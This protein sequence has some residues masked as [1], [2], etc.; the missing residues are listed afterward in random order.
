MISYDVVRFGAP[1]ERFE[2]PTPTP[3]GTEVL[4]K[5]IAAGV[6]HS[7]I[8]IRSGE[9][10]LGGGK[11]LQMG[12]RG[13]NLPL[14]MGHETV[15]EVIA[16]GPGATGVKAGD[17]RLVFPW[18]GCGTCAVCTRGDENLCMKAR[19]LGVYTPG[20]YSDHIVVPHPRY[21]VDIGDLPPEQ[22][23]P[24][25]CSG[26][27]TYSALRKIPAAVLER[28]PVVILG[29]GGL[30]L[31][32]VQILQAMGGH[33]SIV[34]DIDPKKREAAKEAGAL[35]VIDGAAPDAAKQLR[36]AAGG[37]IWAAIDYV[38]APATAELAIA[39]LVKGGQ[40]VVV[41]LFGGE[42]SVSLPLLPLRAMTI[43]GSYTG[44][45]AELRDLIALV[46]RTKM[47]PIPVTTR[48]LEEAQ[49]AL[50]DL[51]HGRQIGRA[52]LQPRF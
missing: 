14:T 11:T 15:G 52:V 1:L 34:V 29:A 26:I 41:G 13:V 12:E 16:A 30:G 42:I 36:D 4:L 32:C 39:C 27:T 6:C 23:A 38:G 2:R 51:E 25:A 46:R 47:P 24:Y 49:A 43:Q 50:V 8:H 7:D 33:G 22:A 5:V 10:D 20:G 19:A 9:Y 44:N 28:E 35:A 45:L 31:M 21:L 40:L 17:R 48:P 18:I 3:T 37:P